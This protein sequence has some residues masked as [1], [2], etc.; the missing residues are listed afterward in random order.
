LS[1]GATGDRRGDPRRTEDRILQLLAS[2]AEEVL[3]VVDS[4][5]R[6]TYVTPAA[7]GLFGWSAEELRGRL[8][9]DLYDA[10]DYEAMVNPDAASDRRRRTRL[11]CRHRDGGWRTVEARARR[12][13]QA[14]PG[15]DAELVI[16][17]RDVTEE[18]RARRQLRESDERLT[19]VFDNAPIGIA[20]VGLD[21]RVL[22]ANPTLCALLGYS[23][24]ELVGMQANAIILPPDRGERGDALAE[25]LDGRAQSAVYDVR[26]V[27][28]DGQAREGEVIASVLRNEK[29]AVRSVLALMQDVTER[30]ELAVQLSAQADLIQHAHDAIFVKQLQ[31]STITFW[32]SG[33]EA[34]YG[35]D[36]ATAVGRVSHELLGTQFGTSLSEVE[37][38]LRLTGEWSGELMQMT[39]A[40]DPVWVQSRWALIRDSDGRP[41]AALEVNRDVT[42]ERQLAY[43]RE[44]LL[45]ILEQ[46]N[47][48]LRE[49]DKLKSEFLLTIS[50][51]LRTPL[52]AILGYT[53]LLALE[54]ALAGRDELDVIQRN[55][56]RLLGLI[57]DIL[58]LAQ[59][60]AGEMLLRPAPL[61]IAAVVRRVVEDHQ[62]YAAEKGLDLEVEGAEDP[63]WV[64]ADE[65]AISHV[66]RHLVANAIK[67]TP[68]GSVGVLVETGPAEV[69]VEVVD[70]GI[71]VPQEAREL[72]FKEFRQVDQSV[73]R[74]YGGVGIGLTVVSRLVSLQ[75]GGLGLADRPGGGTVFWFSL[76]VAPSATGEPPQPLS[77]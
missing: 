47:R 35:Y 49:T 45:E 18:A 61:D 51:E 63:T 37:E 75:G 21:G 32:N 59:V 70:T 1:S 2:G 44:R 13:E 26:F 60:Q 77:G 57:E 8:A 64:T 52:T 17:S 56:R 7:A 28:K 24:A 39:R 54:P 66:L 58:T 3:S 29:G 53:D 38:H 10:D 9:A 43:E 20:E 22:D 12:L 74:R 36:A 46:Q 65:T 14:G 27:R 25:I 6:L 4:A 73:T 62:E 23:R 34:L 31:D 5:G 40:G 50:H 68:A 55:S 69:R 16:F 67:F 48:E 30:E 71:G 33:A 42:P 15:V 11:R 19:E 72:V 41:L 76:P